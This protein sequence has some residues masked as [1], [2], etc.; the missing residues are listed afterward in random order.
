MPDFTMLTQPFLLH[1]WVSGTIVAVIAAVI[2]FFIVIRGSAFVAHALPEAGFAGGAGAVYLQ[3]NP[4]YGLIAFS[5]CGALL[6]GSMSKKAHHDAITA[7]MLVTSLGI[8]ALFLGLS[9]RYA[10]GAYALLFG[11]IVGVSTDQI[12]GTAVVGVLCLIGLA[13]LFRPLLLAS[14]SPDIAA[15]RGVPL[16]MLEAALLVIVALASSV[17]VPMVGALLCFSLLIVPNAASVRL[18]RTP[19]SA[20]RL[21][22][23]AS[24]LDVWLAIALA[25]LSGWPIGFFV[26]MISA[27]FYGFARIRPSLHSRQTAHAA[28]KSPLRKSAR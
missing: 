3:L 27:A 14:V 28:F 26:C 18:T 24:V 25:V 2:G 22:L 12:T 15:A 5:V 20:L 4:L 1:T 23:L 6:I 21:A 8:G 11:Q 16:R 9:D 19:G 10:S 7:L 13:V 17:I